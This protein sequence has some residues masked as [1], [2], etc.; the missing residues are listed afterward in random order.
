M[1]KSKKV[2]RLS[3]QDER[4]ILELVAA[5]K[6]LDAIARALDRA[7]KVIV[8]GDLAREMG[9]RSPAKHSNDAKN[10]DAVCRQAGAGHR[11]AQGLTRVMRA[12]H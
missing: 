7:P 9:V 11:P 4:K 8:R 2:K 12:F 3:F 5:S 10:P 6:S 1:R